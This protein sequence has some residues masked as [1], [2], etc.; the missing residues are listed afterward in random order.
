MYRKKKHQSEFVAEDLLL[1][2]MDLEGQTSDAV[3]REHVLN[4]V[5]KDHLGDDDVFT[6]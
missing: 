5:L 4:D 3:D 6:E 1:L 2:K